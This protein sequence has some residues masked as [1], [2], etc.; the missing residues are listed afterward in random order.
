MREAV[1]EVVGAVTGNGRVADKEVVATAT[2]ALRQLPDRFTAEGL[3]DF[4]AC[5]KRGR[6]TDGSE[7]VTLTTQVS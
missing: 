3:K 4:A 7:N 1:G 5:T 6:R 2:Q